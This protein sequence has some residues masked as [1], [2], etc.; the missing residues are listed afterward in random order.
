MNIVF[1][2]CFS[3]AREQTDLKPVPYIS[4]CSSTPSS[5][6]IQPL[7]IPS[8]LPLSA[9]IA[10]WL[11]VFMAMSNDDRSS[12]IEA[13]IRA[14]SNNT[15]QLNQIKNQI[16]PY[17]QRD[18]VRDLPRELALHV[19]KYLP[20]HD[21]AR[22]SRTCRAW[23]DTCNDLLLWK[24]LCQT[25]TIPFKH[26]PTI[27]DESIDNPWKRSYAC[28][29]HLEHVWQHEDPLPEPAVLRGHE[30]F[31]ITCLQFDGKRIVSG[32][33]DNSLKIWSVA[34][35][36]VGE[37]EGEVASIIQHISPPS[38][39]NK[40]WSDTTAECGVV[41]WLTIS[42]LVEVQIEPFACG[43]SPLEHVNTFSMD[44][45]PLSVVWHFMAISSCLDHVMLAFG[46]TE[47]SLLVR[48]F[49]CQCLEYSHRWTAA[50][51]QWPHGGGALCL[52]QWEIC[53][54]RG[55]WSYHPSVATRT[56]AMCS[57]ARRT[58]QSRLLSRRMS[59]LDWDSCTLSACF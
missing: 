18:F 53:G 50:H 8:S 25:Q 4:L 5:K 2:S 35:G 28:H 47:K 37:R 16:E 11:S 40:P 14:C 26:L 43:I 1:S 7:P 15:N 30:E 17:F 51:A 9:E 44:T 20:A 3:N 21:L 23:Y 6:F 10:D 59:F 32:S 46:R 55:L 22:A 57:H 31:V 41:K 45:R 34:T 27:F 49:L 12:A 38:S 33:D 42:S 58:C 52:L 36:Q 29:K 54:F 39:A 19:L 13:L 24:R 56:R 48:Y